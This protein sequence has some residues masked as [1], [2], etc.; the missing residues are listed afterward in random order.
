MSAALVLPFVWALADGR[1]TAPPRPV[2]Y[3]KAPRPQVAFYRKY[4]EAMPGS[5]AAQ[6]VVVKFGAVVVKGANYAHYQVL[7]DR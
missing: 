6:H 7:V 4:T 3:R 5:L 2:H 1:A